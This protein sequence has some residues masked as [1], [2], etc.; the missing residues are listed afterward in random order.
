MG[1][2]SLPT[3]Y[4]DKGGITLYCGDCREILPGL[5]PGSVA[6]LLTDPPYGIENKFGIQKQ[7]TGTRRLEFAWD[8][9]GVTDEVI[10]AVHL[11]MP[12]VAKPGSAFVFCGGDQFGRVLDTLKRGGFVS[13]PAAWVK[14]C[15]PPP[16]PGNWWP[17]GFE[18][19]CY[20][21]Q[22]GAYFGDKNPSRCN[23]FVY[24]S[25]R[26]GQPGKLGHPNQ[27]PLQL[28]KILVNA[29]CKPGGV[30]LDPFSGSGTTLRAAKDLGRRAIGIEIS[31]EYCEMTVNRLRQEVLF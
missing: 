7:K 8:H 5:E 24:D 20:G 16:L 25:Y 18:L 15:P 9:S 10:E 27:K 11:A 3:P 19:A 4:Y 2:V 12:R 30:V 6:T 17:S 14:A 26:H 1:K 22:S 28:I 13:K 23:V 31:E 21:Y 29:L